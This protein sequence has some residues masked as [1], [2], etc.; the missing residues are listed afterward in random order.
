SIAGCMYQVVQ[1]TGP[2]GK[3][4]LKLLPLAKSTGSFEP[5][6]QSSTI[7]NNSKASISSPVHLTSETQLANTTAPSSVQLPVF[8]SPHPGNIFL[9]RTTDTQ[10]SIRAGSEKEILVLK[11]AANTQSSGVPMSV[12]NMA[13]SSSSDQRHTAHMLDSK[14]LPVPAGP[15]ELPSGLHIPAEAE[16]KSVP[17]SFFSPAILQKILTAAARNMARGP[18]STK[19][20]TVI[21]MSPVN[22]VKTVLPKRFP[23]IHPKPTTEASKPSATTATQI[24]NSSSEVATSSCQQAQGT[25]MKWVVEESPQSSAPCLI[26]VKSSND[27]ASRVLRTLSEMKNVEV[28]SADILPLSSSGPG[29][30]QTKITPLKD[31]ALIA[32]NGKVYLLTKRDSGVL[33]AQTDEQ[34]PSSSDASLNKGTSTVIGSPAVDKITN[35]VV[36]LV[37][38]KSKGK[39]LSQKDPK[40]GANSNGSS[41]TVLRTDCKSALVALV[42]SSANQQDSTVT[43][44]K[45]LPVI[46]NIASGVTPV[47]A[48]GTQES[49]CQNGK[50]KIH[51]PKAAGAVLPQPKQECDSTED[52]QKIQCEKMDS[53]EKVIQI[54]HQE[55]PHWEQYLELR[56]KFG[57]FKKERV[58]LKKIPLRTSCEKQEEKVCFSNSLKRRNDSCGSSSSEVEIINEYKECVKE[59]KVIT[60]LEEDLTKKRKRKSSP[61]SDSGKVRKTT[62][63]STPRPTSETTS[64][65]VL[66][67]SVSPT[68]V[69]SQQS[70]PTDFVLSSPGSGCEEEDSQ[71][72]DVTGSDV[73]VLVSCEG[74]TSVLEGSFRDDS[75]LLTPPD[76][77]ET[78]RDEKINRLKQLLREREVAL[79]EVRR[80]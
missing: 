77:D 48:V 55:K 30:S 15:P 24:G 51:S 70:V 73:P 62:V 11:S 38:S 40:P 60:E 76:L 59:E 37:L 6:V 61:L 47:P 54:E 36:N 17:A 46:K 41:P 52:R 33:K 20:P 79:E 45:S 22:I 7:T 4:L 44:E 50:E 43:Q 78:I 63:T 21:Y 64:S 10:E 12:Q 58:Y 16:V 9:T 3:N 31:N 34:A 27:A 72:S 25:P 74:S 69:S 80:K 26:P 68:P 8:S 57:L 19:M 39:V 23:P 18:G 75:F 35:D 2:D 71:Y 42:T 66:N 67:S 65:N 32:Y 1:T 5:V 14:N 28:N 29:G 53:P 56:K 13:V 49:G